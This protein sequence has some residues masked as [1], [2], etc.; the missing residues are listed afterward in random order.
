M[1][2][3]YEISQEVKT[4]LSRGLPVVAL[5]SS[6][7]A[8]GLPGARGAEAAIAMTR[9][10]AEELCTPAVIGIIEGK[11]K[12]G[13]S[14]DEIARFAESGDV[15]KVSTREIA[16]AVFRKKDG[17]TT[18]AATAFLAANSGI[19][20]MATG[21]IGGV[22]R[23]AGESWDISA[24]L[25]EM[26]K[27]SVMVVCSG[28]KSVL[29]LPATIEWLETHQIGVYGYGT[30]EFPA[31]FSAN[32]GLSVPRLDDPKEASELFTTRVGL[33]LRSGMIVGVPIPE[34]SSIDL[35]D[36]IE[37]S[38][39]AAKSEGIT[40]QSLTPWL[41]ARVQELSGGKA[42]DANIALL[43]NNARVAAKIAASVGGR[44][45]KRIGFLA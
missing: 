4:A 14:E 33:G 44:E 43:K 38:V 11:I 24:D 13:L 34:E 22:H 29:D 39:A 42:I 16:E 7:I 45:E 20:V 2:E 10:I 28:A 25:W 37:Q 6:V 19:Q 1:I 15:M 3:P 23:G 9:E 30:G 35:T 8:Q 26:A 17:A 36:A 41:L 32:S 27:T 18:V 40:G 21:G 31:F 12:I 5:E